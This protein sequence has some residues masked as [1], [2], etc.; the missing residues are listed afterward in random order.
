MTLLLPFEG[1]N[2]ITSAYGERI[3]NGVPDYH[4][5][6]DVVG[7]DSGIVR[8]PCDAI[9]GTSAIVTDHADRTW[10]WGNF[11]RVDTGFGLY[12]FYCHLAERYVKAGQKVKAGQPIGLMGNTG[13]S[14]GAHTHVEVRVDS[15]AA[16]APAAYFGIEN[17]EGIYESEKE[18]TEL[19]KAEIKQIVVEVIAELEAK[20]KEE[21]APGWAIDELTEAVNAEITDGSRPMEN[22][23]RYQGAI[24][25]KRALVKAEELMTKISA[26][27]ER[28]SADMGDMR[29]DIG[30]IRSRLK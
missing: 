25:V 11:I 6:L 14:F 12:I 20:K 19:T 27:I 17:R 16:I 22:L 24:M 21:G 30:D 9:I 28:L 2:K 4:P 18:E 8:A 5:G 26:K 29:R 1:R 23:P 7:V 13:Y 15:G 3:L 10:E